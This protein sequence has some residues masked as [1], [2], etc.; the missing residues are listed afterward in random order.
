MTQAVREARYGPHRW[1]QDTHATCWLVLMFYHC[2][3][4]GRACSSKSPGPEPGVCDCKA[5]LLQHTSQSP[6]RSLCPVPSKLEGVGALTFSH[7][8]RGSC[9]LLERHWV[10]STR[11]CSTLSDLAQNFIGTLRKALREIQLTT[12]L[13]LKLV[14]MCYIIQCDCEL[15]CS[16]FFF[17]L[18]VTLQVAVFDILSSNQV[19]WRTD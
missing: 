12:S 10:H 19:S 1:P 15:F 8:F 18:Q 4:R 14:R 2:G 7:F 13:N 3:I 6:S 11:R 17:F 9:K 5:L 16:I